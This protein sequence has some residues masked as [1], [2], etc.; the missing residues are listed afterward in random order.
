MDKIFV[1]IASYRDAELP[2]TINSALSHATHPNRVTFGI[3]WQYDEQTYLD[4]DPYI[5][6][7]NIRVHQMYYESSKGC[8]WARHHTDQLYDGEKYM[9]QI[10]AHTRFAEDWDVKFIQM[11][12]SLD[13][14]KPILSTYPAPFDYVDGEEQLFNDRGMQR[15]V[16]KKMKKDLTTIF[17]STPV[18]DTS[19]PAP[20]QFLAAGQLFTYGQFCQEVEY[21]PELYFIGEEISLSA[22]AYTQGYDF[23]CPNEDLLWHYYQHPMPLHS[24]DHTKNQNLS[25]ILRLQDLFLKDHNTLGKYGLGSVRSLADYERFADLDFY[26]SF[27]RK[28]ERTHLKTKIP[29]N[30]SAIEQ[31]DDYDY[32]IFTLRN[33]DDEE[34]YRQNLVGHDIP[35]RERSSLNIDLQLS[36]KPVSY[37]L[38]PHSKEHGYL[39]RHCEDY[40][41]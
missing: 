8:C 10:D 31:R 24:A 37:T 13:C 35:T 23:F 32:W 30:L 4:L 5:E 27:N 1:K 11:L 26:G 33:I 38:L 20:S 36:D 29:L 28:P 19:R 16:L 18:D 2:K 41:F 14:E 21:D 7:S 17:G 22:R 12:E 25:A 9:L 15:L 40:E 39:P 34:I 6:S 3:C